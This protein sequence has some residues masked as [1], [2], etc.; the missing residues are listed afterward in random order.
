[1]ESGFPP[2]SCQMPQLPALPIG[3]IE[4]LIRHIFPLDFLKYTIE[5]DHLISKHK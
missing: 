2:I 1:M 3:K 5:E 4:T